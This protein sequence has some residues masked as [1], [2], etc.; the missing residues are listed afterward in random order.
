MN[1]LLVDTFYPRYEYKMVV[2]VNVL[3]QLAIT[4]NLFCKV[5][6]S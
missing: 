2:M 4:S 6:E 3:K 1:E 5:T